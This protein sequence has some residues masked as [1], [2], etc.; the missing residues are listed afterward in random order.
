MSRPAASNRD[1]IMKTLYMMWCSAV[2]HSNV[3]F[4]V[5]EQKLHSVYLY[6]LQRGRLQVRYV[7]TPFIAG[8]VKSYGFVNFT[9]F[10]SCILHVYEHMYFCVSV[11]ARV[12]VLCPMRYVSRGLSNSDDSRGCT[13]NSISV[14]ESQH[15]TSNAQWCM[16]HPFGWALFLMSLEVQAEVDRIQLDVSLVLL[17]KIIFLIFFL[18]T[19]TLKAE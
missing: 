12:C 11:C 19:S 4:I 15:S 1:S 8:L 5:G 18:Q 3:A 14:L 9:M 16:T 6:V 2:H 10:A 17:T 13:G 7:R